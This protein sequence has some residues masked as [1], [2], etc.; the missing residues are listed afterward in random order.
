VIAI[1][2]AVRES[3]PEVEIAAS[4][5]GHSRSEDLTQDEQDGQAIKPG[6]GTS[7]ANQAY[8]MGTG[9]RADRKLLRPPFTHDAVERTADGASVI[10]SRPGPSG[11]TGRR[12]EQ[13]TPAG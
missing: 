12:A 8:T 9:P 4:Q 10:G 2:P 6:I 3:G 5:N 7:R 13:A 11:I 1:A